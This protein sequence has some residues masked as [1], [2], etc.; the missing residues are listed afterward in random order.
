MKIVRLIIR[1]ILAL[2]LFIP[3]YVVTFTA[4]S[5]FGILPFAALIVI[6]F[7]CL[8]LLLENSDYD[9]YNRQEDIKFTGYIIVAPF[10][11]PIQMTK[12]FIIGNNPFKNL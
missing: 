12:E 9:K 5:I 7:Q 11:A 6:P 4:M 8:Q 3:F 10:I 1:I 2:I